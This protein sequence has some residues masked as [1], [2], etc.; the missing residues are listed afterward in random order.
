MGPGVHDTLTV[1][2]YT[3]LIW[4]QSAV[5]IQVTLWINQSPSLASSRWKSGCRMLHL[6]HTAHLMTTCCPG[7]RPRVWSRPSRQVNRH[8]SCVSCKTD[9]IWYWWYSLLDS[10][11]LWNH[12]LGVTGL[13][14]SS[15]YYWR[16]TLKQELNDVL[17][18]IATFML[19][20]QYEY[21]RVMC[22][23]CTADMFFTKL[24]FTWVN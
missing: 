1:L 24:G 15:D 11:G 7:C 2:F 20:V 19:P 14:M 17:H 16:Q 6:T 18:V 13:F 21:L 10:G 12:T 9:A 4:W 5:H 8:V 3:Q 22:N 23:T